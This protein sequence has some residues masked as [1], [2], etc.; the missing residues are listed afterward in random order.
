LVKKSVLLIGPEPER[1][2]RLKRVHESLLD[3]GVNVKVLVPFKKP[4]GR[5]RILTGIIRYLTITLQ[6]LLT[7]ADIYHFF[8]IPDS[9]G[10]PLVVKQ[11]TLVYDVRSPWAEVIEITFGRSPLVK[12]ARL[13]ERFL[14]V[15]SD[16]VVCVNRLLGVRAKKWGAK[17][18]AVIPNYPSD[19]FGSKRNRED[20]RMMLGL[21]DSQVVLYV[22]KISTVEGVGLLMD[23]IREVA[24]AAPKVR[25]LVVGDGPQEEELRSFIASQGLENR[26]TM[27]GWIAH[28]EVADYIEAADLCLLPRPWNS[29]SP[30][31]A[32]E[33]IWKAGE[34][35]SLGKPVVAP[36]MGDFASASY[37]LIPVDPDE[38][39]RAIVEFFRRP[40]PKSTKPYPRWSESH[41]RLEKFYRALGAL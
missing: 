30:L 16:Y 23:V 14:T 37:P 19:D 7:K 28:D 12:I 25:F 22:G 5:P 15:K 8:N 17:S 4:R 1:M 27:A 24:P 11:G 20:T 34:Y 6:V 32:P 9:I 18:V 13:I 21:S 36:R 35:L 31:T 41:R 10:L 33:S 39:G 38:M 3:L 29:A 2:I 26:V 40:Q